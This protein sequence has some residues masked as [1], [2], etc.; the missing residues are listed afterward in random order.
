VA[1]ADGAG[2][3]QCFAFEEELRPEAAAV[4]AAL[5][6]RGIEVAI[7]SGD[8]AAA[9]A[10][11]ASQLGIETALSRQSPADKA[12]WLAAHAAEGR[13]VLMVGD[14]LNDTAALGAAH[15]SLAP[16]SG[17]EAARS[18]VDVVMVSV[19][20]GRVADLIGTVRHSLGRMRQ[21]IAIALIYN[22]GAIP[23][24]LAG[25][26]SPLLAALAMSLSSL[27]VTLNAV[28]RSP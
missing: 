14:G 11:I 15:A 19:G 1:L 2:G 10:R 17:L 6:A 12:A 5:R 23:V 7:L 18:L 26:A 4:V 3:S 22:C 16:A 8:G 28:R 13:R 25:L 24:A 27:N 20:L 9:V 21:N